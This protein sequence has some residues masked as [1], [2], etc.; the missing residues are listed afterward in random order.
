MVHPDTAALS[1]FKQSISTLDLH[2]GGEPLRLVIDGLPP[3]PGKTINDKRIYLSEHLDQVRLL[4]NREPR[5]HR[6]MFS[7]VV[8]EPVSEG[9]HFGIVFMDAKRYPYMCGHGIMAAVTAFIEM[10]W[11]DSQD[12]ENAVT[13]DTPSGP[14]LARALVRTREGTRPLV[15]SVAVRLE[16]AFVF[17]LDQQV[18]LPGTGSVTVD[19][20]F[21]GGFF[22][23]VPVDRVGLTL[24][25]EHTGELSRLGM[26]LIEAGNRQLTVRHPLRHYIDTVD[27]AE[28][29]DPSGH[30]RLH[31]KNLVILGEGHVDRSP[32]GT[33]T[34][35]KLALLHR[36]GELAQGN[37]LLNEGLMGATFEGRILEEI[38]VGAFPAVVPEI[39]GTAFI[40]GYHRFVLSTHDPFPGGFLI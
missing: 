40:T 18:E 11:L 32:C 4:L 3:L 17:S 20:V 21:A 15:E 38:T 23:M 39:S 33:G 13:V 8:T 26:A 6:D 19:V 24:T 37:T 36:K 9:A 10:G 35:A 16:S 31:G 29:Y 27:V 2:V 7:A 14:I 34:S 28:F 30:H 25:P 12:G 22:L 1:S 5:G